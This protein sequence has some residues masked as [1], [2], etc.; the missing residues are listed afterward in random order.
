LWRETATT[1]IN[2]RS[3]KLLKIIVSYMLGPFGMMLQNFYIKNSLIINS[4]IVLYGLFLFVANLNYKKILEFALLQ[5]EENNKNN[6]KGNKV[7]DQEISW[8]EAID[9]GSFFPFIVG[10]LSFIPQK[11]SIS[12]MIKLTNKD[13]NWHKINSKKKQ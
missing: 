12:N 4:F 1:N 5:V 10:A 3:H 6:K 13:K 8:S 2:A 7:K 11:V 9:K